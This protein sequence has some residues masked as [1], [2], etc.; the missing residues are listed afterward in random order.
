[1][2]DNKKKQIKETSKKN[3]TKN[4]SLDAYKPKEQV[5]D[6]LRIISDDEDSHR[7]FCVLSLN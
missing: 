1:M 3:T 4:Q 7:N 2:R 5:N 6:S